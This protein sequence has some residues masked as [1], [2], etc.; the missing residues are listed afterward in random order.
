[1]ESAHVTKS[2]KFS[3]GMTDES[4]LKFGDKTLSLS[5]VKDLLKDNDA[6]PPS[7]ILVFW[8]DIMQMTSLGLIQIVAKSQ[9]IE[10]DI[11]SL[12][13]RDTPTLWYYAVGDIIKKKLQMSDEDIKCLYD[14]FYSEILRN[15]YVTYQYFRLALMSEIVKDIT[16]VFHKEVPEIELIKDKMVS[17]MRAGTNINVLIRDRFNQETT[18]NEVTHDIIMTEYGEYAFVRAIN[19]KISNYGILASLRHN[20]ELNAYVGIMHKLSKDIGMDRVIYPYGIQVLLYE[21]DS[22]Y[23]SGDK[24]RSSG[25]EQ[26]H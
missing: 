1:M 7:S 25:D 5:A 13:Y 22:L 21:E 8:D 17:D 3:E 19:N 20:D 9:S 16:V 26:K 11:P 23:G 24:E 18:I 6:P 4:L 14:D 2:Q 12:M 10:F 15:A